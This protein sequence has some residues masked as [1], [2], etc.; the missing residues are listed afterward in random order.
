[1]KKI[2]KEDV[3]VVMNAAT[4]IYIVGEKYGITGGS[5]DTAYAEAIKSLDVKIRRDKDEKSG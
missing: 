1:M 2:S 3:L 5:L 4:I